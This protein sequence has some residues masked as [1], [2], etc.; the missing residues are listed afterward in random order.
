MILPSSSS[1]S[2]S[3]GVVDHC[4]VFCHCSGASDDL[5]ALSSSV[6]KLH[7]PLGLHGCETASAPGATSAWESTVSRPN[8]SRS[9]SSQGY[10]PLETPGVG[11]HRMQVE[12]SWPPQASGYRGP[13]LVLALI[14][15]SRT[16]HCWSLIF[17]GGVSVPSVSLSSPP[18]RS[19][20]TL[21]T[22]GVKGLL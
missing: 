13:K 22:R 5:T 11:W 12:H 15:G 3:W 14:S 18:A 4:H 2:S 7:R 6:Y 21:A 8:L 9:R 16:W 19:P 20:L 1:F 17:F 10:N